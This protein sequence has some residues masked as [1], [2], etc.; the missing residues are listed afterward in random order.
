MESTN[1]DFRTREKN[2]KYQ[3]NGSKNEKKQTLCLSLEDR[4]R[5]GKRIWNIGRAVLAGNRY[6]VWGSFAYPNFSYGEPLSS[7]WEAN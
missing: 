4:G 7:Q 1:R 6:F 5:R 3:S 2:R